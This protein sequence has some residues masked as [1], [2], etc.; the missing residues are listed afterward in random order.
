MLTPQERASIIEVVRDV[1]RTEITPH[2]RN[3]DLAAIDSKS[4]PDDLVTIAD[5]AAEA[6]MTERFSKIFPDASI[7]GEEA[8]SADK[9]LLDK[10]D[11]PGQC[12]VIDPIDGTWNFAHGIATYG[13]IIAVIEDGK[14]VFGMLYDPSFDDWVWAGYGDGAHYTRG[15]GRTTHL[16]LPEPPVALNDTF[17]FVGMFLY[18]KS[19]QAVIAKEL[20]RFRRAVTLR[21]ACH[22]YRH[23]AM[24]NAAFCLNGMLNVW[25]HA[26]GVLIYQ[27]AGGVA[28]LLDGSEYHP[29]MT[30]GRLLT[31]QSKRLWKD[32]SEI[33]EALA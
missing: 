4:A 3:L 33:F 20:P 26:A 7:I 10:V 13:V 16:S 30:T 23:L 1:A 9:S 25:D 12:I 2:F 17:G 14:T 27:E 32:L 24:G 15:D 6:A 31:A 5:R 22:E 19:D 8:V 18:N 29:T 21:T 11:G 28:R